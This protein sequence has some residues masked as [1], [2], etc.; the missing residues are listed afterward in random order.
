MTETNPQ[1]C[2]GRRVAKFK[3]L[4][5]SPDAL[6]SNMTKAGLPNPLIEVRIADPE[7]LDREMPHGQQ[8]ELL[9]RGPT[10][11]TN[12]F[13]VDAPDKFH[14]GWLVTGDV[15]KLDEEGAIIICDRSKDVIKS[16][17]EWISS[18]DLENHISGMNEIAVAAVVAVPHPRWDERPVA[19]VTLPAGSGPGKEQGLKERV[20]S[21]CLKAFA[22]FQV[23]DDVIIWKEIR[24]TSTGKLDKRSI[25][26]KLSSQSYVL[27]KTMEAKSKL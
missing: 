18:I 26:E 6:F 12:Y 2:W 20:V 1:G 4:S 10:V 21:H 24:L 13:Q 15:A 8:G 9:V 7:D 5:A 16:G 3:D 19:V 23:P 25:R 14:L 17:G 22:K 11:I 27:P